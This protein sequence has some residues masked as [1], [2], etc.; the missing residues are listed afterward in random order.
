MNYSLSDAV[1]ICENLIRIVETNETSRR[2]D[3]SFI[4]KVEGLILCFQ[5]HIK[6]LL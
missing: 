1:L 2:Y 3:D 4:L 5:H 6:S